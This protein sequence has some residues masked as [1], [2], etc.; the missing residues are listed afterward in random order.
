MNCVPI[1]DGAVGSLQQLGIDFAIVGFTELGASSVD[2]T[3]VVVVVALVEVSP[4]ESKVF[5]LI[6]AMESRY[7][8]VT[9]Y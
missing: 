5:S 4:I 6:M 3:D 7:I 2:S 8:L 1:S 9:L